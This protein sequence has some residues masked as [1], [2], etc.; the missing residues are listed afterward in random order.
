MRG[1]VKHA[2]VYEADQSFSQSI[3]YFLEPVNCEGEPTWIKYTD[4]EINGRSPGDRVVYV[5]MIGTKFADGTTT[6]SIICNSDG[7][8]EEI[9][10]GPECK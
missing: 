3:K 9:S 7:S 4:Y 6:R 8:W 5:A 2:I 10:E 1:L